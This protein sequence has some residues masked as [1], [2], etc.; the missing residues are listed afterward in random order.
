MVDFGEVSI[1]SLS[2]KTLDFLNTLD[3]PIMVEIENDCPE[4]AQSSP[5]S[6]I[7]QPQAKGTFTL[8]FESDYVQ[9]FQR[10]ITYRINYSYRHHLII[11]ADCK[12]P[13]VK[14]NKNHLVLTQLT[15]VQADLCYRSNVTVINPFNTMVEF[16]WVPIYGEQGT[17]FSV[18]PAAGVIEP[19]Q[20]LECEVVWHGSSLAPNKGTFSLQV[21]GGEATSLTCEAKIG[22]SQIQFI[23]RRANFGK[24][25]VNMK[26]TRTFHLTNT[27]THNAYFQILDNM[28]VPGMVI[29]PMFGIAPVNA[30]TPIRIE[31]NPVETMKF[32]AKVLIQVRGGRQLELRLSG[33]SEEPLIDFDLPNFDFGGIYTGAS[34][35]LPFKLSNKS[36]VKG[37][38]EFD[39]KKYPDFSVRPKDKSIPI[40]INDKRYEITLSGGQTIEMEFVFTPSGV[41]SYDFDL[42]I[43]VNKREQLEL[44]DEY[45]NMISNTPYMSSMQ[46]SALRDKRYQSPTRKSSRSSVLATTPKK[47]VT[48]VGLRKALELS[49]SCLWFKVPITYYEKLKEGGFCEVKSVVMTNRS[50][51]AVKW[52]LDMRNPSKVLDDGKFKICDG[53]MIPFVNTDKKSIGPEGE[54]GP[55]ESYEIKVLFCPDK[56]GIYSC[57]LP[58]VVNQNYDHPYY[59]VEINGELMT[60]E[61]FFDPDVLVFK[62]VPLGLETTELLTIKQKGYETKSKLR[63]VI[64]EAKTL[65]GESIQVLKAD[66]VN[67]PVILPDENHRI[68]INL[69]FS[70]SKP[71]STTIRLKF[72]DEQNREYEFSTIVTADNSLFTCYSFLADN[73]NAYHIVSDQSSQVRGGNHVASTSLFGDAF[74]DPILRPY[75]GTSHLSRNGVTPTFDVHD[76]MDDGLKEVD[77]NGF[78]QAN[79]SMSRFES[80]MSTAFIKALDPLLFPSVETN[81]GLYTNQVLRA[82]ERWYKCNGWPTSHNLVKIPESFRAG[83]SR[84]PLEDNEE[85]MPQQDAMKRETK[86]IYEMITHLSGRQLPAI[87]QLAPIPNDLAERTFQFHW[88]HNV[89]L[90]FLEA[91]GG[92]IAGIKAEYLLDTGEFRTYIDQINRKKSQEETSSGF[93]NTQNECI[94]APR[95]SLTIFPLVSKKAWLDCLLQA[96]KVFIFNRITPKSF[97]SMPVP[98]DKEATFPDVKSDPL[99]SN[100]YSTGERILLAWLNYCYSSY[101]DK[102]WPGRSTPSKWIV[103]FDID[104]TDSLAL[105]VVIGTYCPYII[106]SHLSRMYLSADTAEKCFHN[107]LI[108]VDCCRELGFDYDL[109]SL[110]IT[111][112]NAIGMALFVAYI[113]N[114]LPNYIPCSS[115][116]FNGPLHTTVPKQVKI[117]NPISKNIF[118]EAL[119]IGPNKE[120]F[121]FPKGKEL[122]V[123]SR[124]R[125]NL[126]VDYYS[127]NLKPAYAHLILV[128]KKN[129]SVAAEPLVF[130]LKANVNELTAKKIIKFQSGLYKQTESRLEIE[131]P[132]DQAGHFSIKVLETGEKSDSISNPF[133]TSSNANT[134]KQNLVSNSNVINAVSNANTNKGG[135]AANGKMKALFGRKESIVTE[136]PV[137]LSTPIL[138]AFYTKQE[139]IYLEAK[140][141]AVITVSYLPLQSVK[142]GAV[143]LFTNEK[144]GE[145]VYHLEGTAAQPEPI[146]VQVD[147]GALDP[148]K[149]KYIKSSR[150]D[151]KTLTFR[152]FMGDKIDICLLV[153]VCNQERENAV[154]K[155]AE[156][157]MSELEL[158]RRRVHGVLS[159]KSLLEALDLLTV[160]KSKINNSTNSKSSLTGKTK[161][162]NLTFTVAVKN[163][164]FIQ[165]PSSLTI[166]SESLKSDENTIP[167]RIKFNADR[168]GY[169]QSF[170][171]LKSLPDDIRIIPVDFKITDNFVSDNTSPSLQF[172]S[173]VF[174]P[175]VQPIPIKNNSEMAVNYEAEIIG[176]VNDKNAFKGPTK[177]TI[178]AKDI[179][180][181]ELVFLPNAEEKFE[182]ELVLNNLTEGI[183]SKYVLT[184]VGEKKPALGEIKLDTRVGQVTQHEI[185]IPNKSN[186]KIC[187]YVS[188]NSPFIQGPDKIMLLPNRKETYKFEICPTQRGEFKGAITFNPG[189]W[190][191]KD[192]DSDGEE[193]AKMFN[194]EK[195][196]QFTLWFTFDLKVNPAA[197]QSTIELEAHVLDSGTVC[198][199]LSNPLNK[200]LEFQV[201]KTGQYLDGAEKFTIA[202]KEKFNYELKFCPKRV[203]K[204]KGSLVFLNNETGEFWYELRLVAVDALPFS[205]DP[206]EA[207]LGRFGVK[208][209]S[210]KN[211]L[212]EA[213]EFRV[214][215]SNTDN[216]NVESN[217]LTNDT[218][219]VDA[220]G[221]VDVNIKFNPST[222]GPADHVGLI[223]FFNERIGNL[224]YEVSGIG[225]EPDTQDPINI[226]AEVN[227]SQMVTVYFRNTTDSA[228]YCDMSLLDDTTDKPFEESDPD[229]PIFNIL[230]NNVASVH[231]PPRGSLDI[232]IVFKPNELRSYSVNLVVSARR[233]ARMSWNEKDPNRKLDRLQWIYPIKAFSVINA[234]N[235]ST[236]FQIE[237]SVRKRLEKRMEIV[238]SNVSSYYTSSDR[239]SPL[240]VRS[241][242]PYKASATPESIDSPKSKNSDQESAA[243][244]NNTT[245]AQEFTYNI[246]FFGN[247]DQCQTAG[248]SIAIKLVRTQRDKT[249]GL[250]TLIFDL[251]FCPSKSFM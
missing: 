68:E 117:T 212:N 38:V 169:F 56:P 125:A 52:C 154:T 110:D 179:Y 120:S 239:R 118:Y 148:N 147:E 232:P 220:N 250:V 47:K 137:D 226:T 7:I 210:L 143:L 96:L 107:A 15:G 248:N 31:M 201:T 62:P 123:S 131:N 151:D 104:L 61:I 40:A 249:N 205:L 223:S 237:C 229:S 132:Y 21:T 16:T 204:F 58:I 221:S 134:T 29:T 166:D 208:T 99:T 128:G 60:P 180:S 187:F 145:F 182:A 222:I 3:Q 86:T 26:S 42:P 83:V 174:D 219:S 192:V 75:S 139:S 233:E 41:A 102:I 234:I 81:S 245:L 214:I 199:P 211:P 193:M 197:K 224:T 215:V 33:E 159:S 28:P 100:I 2:V 59:N 112:P 173:C 69:K 10:S 242:T 1:N 39:L 196:P 133:S 195:P 8:A 113:F 175:I 228:I 35:A 156:Q 142:H 129:A 176:K 64:P 167:L 152:C 121:S 30:V 241:V 49:T 71:I 244:A 87:P 103:N 130:N 246:Q 251:I 146:K 230:M 67:D 124:G 109:T 44:L 70:S 119:I 36:Q 66:F 97:K 231:V 140:G 76:A 20:E 34:C 184:G 32:D 77:E 190:P 27:G 209:I 216:F 106:D 247:S 243:N 186:K 206:I 84:K 13:S 51:R 17:A 181:Y 95:V 114:K 227:H 24:I 37:K 161:T 213:L 238:L 105:A 235:K 14:L 150:F 91:G 160:N 92:C 53:S 85:S 54:I 88:Q 82:L 79:R 90:K 94:D 177:F 240:R 194:D 45:D 12:L 5:L 4:L 225:L 207:E 162:S 108:L 101:K 164:M 172:T 153:P 171:E 50:H 6:Q 157:R 9:T 144:L 189:E 23:N 218:I 57:N 93:K 217:Q 170:I 63:L 155:A 183:I 98:Y 78:N 43:T 111:D 168:T 138:S 203:G 46:A 115:I 19:H 135:K 65:E 48:A 200:S 80:R 22:S 89:L 178:Q 74:G 163:S 191:I 18:R 25:P 236:P 73:H 149:I 72:I 122:A 11:L 165:T 202:P 141:K 188:S 185:Q 198:I 126:A 55:N 158:K 136:E 127:D 116:E